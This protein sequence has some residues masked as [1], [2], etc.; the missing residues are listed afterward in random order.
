MP[1]PEPKIIVDNK[2]SQKSQQT[3]NILRRMVAFEGEAL[4]AQDRLTLKHIA[5][6]KARVLLPIGHAFLCVRAGHH[7]NIEAISN[8]AI[9]NKQ[10]P[11][12]QWLSPYFK[13]Q[14]QSG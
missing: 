9:V 11:F 6:N 1:K 13:I 10:A 4:Q 5:V 7:I 14:G 2:P 8:Q 3:D 12:I